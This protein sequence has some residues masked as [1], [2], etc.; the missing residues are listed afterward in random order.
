VFYLLPSYLHWATL[1]LQVSNGNWATLGYLSLV[2]G[3]IISEKS[4]NLTA[5]ICGNQLTVDG[6]K[7][8]ADDWQ[9][10]L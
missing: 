10:P 8:T 7:D 1:G 4:G 6:R 2:V 3:A 9:C 5:V